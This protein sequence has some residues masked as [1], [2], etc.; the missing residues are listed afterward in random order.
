MQAIFAAALSNALVAGVLGVLN[1]VLGR[2]LRRPA[3]IHCLWIVVLAKLITPPLIPINLAHNTS[4]DGRPIPLVDPEAN[5]VK[6]V[7]A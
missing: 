2:V 5:P 4:N 1:F 6:E 3:L 7:W